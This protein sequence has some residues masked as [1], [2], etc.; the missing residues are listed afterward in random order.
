[1][2]AKPKMIRVLKVNLLAVAVLF[3]HSMSAL[4]YND[5][6]GGEGPNCDVQ[7]GPKGSYMEFVCNG[8][9]EPE[10]GECKQ[11]AEDQ[12]SCCWMEHS[13]R[14]RSTS[15]VK[16]E[17]VRKSIK[18]RENRIREVCVDIRAA[19]EEKKVPALCA[20]EGDCTKLKNDDDKIACYT[21]IAHCKAA[22]QG[23][24]KR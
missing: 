24:T 11:D 1:L 18:V 23:L 17:V 16:L 7:Y 9:D 13:A 15:S 21:Q 19:Q 14:L 12:R 20:D 2:G 8:F 4:A 5:R 22:N 10:Y 6:P 3:W